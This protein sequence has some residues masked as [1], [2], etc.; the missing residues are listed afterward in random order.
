MKAK[1]DSFERGVKYSKLSQNMDKASK[2]IIFG[3][4]NDFPL[5]K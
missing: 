2:E 1:R 3:R 5:H 4:R